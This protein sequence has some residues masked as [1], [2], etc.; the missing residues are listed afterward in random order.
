MRG[1]GSTE[2]D[3]SAGENTERAFVQQLYLWFRDS[4][5]AWVGTAAELL[6]ELKGR[7]DGL[8]GERWPEN[9]VAVCSQ[10]ERYTELLR[11]YG[12]EVHILQQDNGPRL[13]SIRQLKETAVVDTQ[14]GQP[15]SSRIGDA[16]EKVVADEVMNA[17]RNEPGWQQAE[18]HSG[19]EEQALGDSADL[20]LESTPAEST[21]ANVNATPSDLRAN[22][23]HHQRQQPISPSPDF[24]D[25]SDWHDIRTSL[26]GFDTG[27]TVPSGIGHRMIIA[28]IVILSVVG[29]LL[30]FA[31]IWPETFP[32][33]L[34]ANSTAQSNSALQRSRTQE[35][36]APKISHGELVASNGGAGNKAAMVPEGVPQLLQNSRAG[37]ADAQ[38]LLGR[39][40]EIGAGVEQDFVNAYA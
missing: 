26:S 40:Y 33:A 28:G 6:S 39:A 29:V 17:D 12:L 21:P 31:W 37:D 22:S 32:I 14:E 19:I 25:P 23:D 35:S 11:S 3:I 36:D 7:A 20:H 5:S 10:L 4:A 8:E 2:P 24:A 30:L 15:N 13:I 38:Y 1:Q 16:D 18:E 9:A 34:F 27:N